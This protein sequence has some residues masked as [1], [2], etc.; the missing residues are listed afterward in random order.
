MKNQSLL[1]K[2]TYASFVLVVAFIL[3]TISGYNKVYNDAQWA[4]AKEKG[5]IA[6][7]I[8]TS[9]T[10][11]AKAYVEDNSVKADERYKNKTV[12][13]VGT[14]DILGQELS[15]RYIILSSE[16]G[17]PN[18]QLFLKKESE[19]NKLGKLN[20]GD[21]VTAQGVVAGKLKSKNVAVTDCILK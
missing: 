9:S 1:K 18:V 15:Q 16:K 4:K 7:T 12:E 8:K 6:T 3:I 14:V 17:I 11:L 20:R 13:I 5:T 21:T 10:E 2:V 19:I